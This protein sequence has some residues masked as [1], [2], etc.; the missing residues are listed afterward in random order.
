MPTVP[1]TIEIDEGQQRRR[2]RRQGPRLAGQER[3]AQQHDRADGRGDR[4]PDE[5]R[6]RVVGSLA[7]RSRRPRTT[8][9]PPRARGSRSA[10]RSRRPPTPYDQADSG[11]SDQSAGDGPPAEPLHPDLPRPSASVDQWPESQ[12][13][14][15]PGRPVARTRPRYRN[16][17]NAAN[18]RR[19]Y[20]T[21]PRRAVRRPGGRRA[22]HATPSVVNRIAASAKRSPAFQNGASVRFVNRIAT[23][24][25]PT[26]TT[27]AANARDELYSRS[28]GR[29]AERGRSR[30]RR[31]SA[32][33]QRLDVERRVDP[34]V[35]RRSTPTAASRSGKRRIEAQDR[36]PSRAR[37]T[38]AIAPLVVDHEAALDRR[39][40]RAGSG[41]CSAPR[42]RS[43][44]RRRRTSP[45]NA[46]LARAGRP[47]PRRRRSWQSRALG[48]R[49][50]SSTSPVGAAPSAVRELGAVDP[51]RRSW[52]AVRPTRSTSSGRGSSVAAWNVRQVDVR[53]RRSRPGRP[54]RAGASS[55]GSA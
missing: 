25:A 2:I 37:S 17:K 19:P 24:F 51:C 1:G 45:R 54:A 52:P 34:E 32:A 6:S 29:S 20:A 41:A 49:R 36:R 28:A 21:P 8:Q 15:S 26:R 11:E 50:R 48:R 47:S 14:L 33:E 18:A 38:S 10:G 7:R 43:T 27:R 35:C 12:E 9:P 23:M 5:R 16:P 31:R 42:A 44:S 46:A 22:A 3:H 30:R 55:G 4:V 40:G 53:A 13:D 39:A